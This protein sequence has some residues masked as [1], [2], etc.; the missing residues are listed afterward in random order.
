MLRRCMNHTKKNESKKYITK[1]QQDHIA[2]DFSPQIPWFVH[3]FTAS[4]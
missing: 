3:S 4:A 1:I 2:L